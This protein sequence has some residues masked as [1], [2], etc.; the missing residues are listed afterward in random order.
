MLYS[1]I[2]IWDA[3]VIAYLSKEQKKIIGE[4]LSLVSSLLPEPYSLSQ[5]IILV[6]AIY[7]QLLIL[8]G[9]DK[10]DV[11]ELISPLYRYCNWAQS[12]C[13]YANTHHSEGPSQKSR[14][15]CVIEEDM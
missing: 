10:Y 13:F 12:F 4:W 7:P 15:C 2:N 1:K 14:T 11:S 9:L 3:N 6:R 5:C 8:C